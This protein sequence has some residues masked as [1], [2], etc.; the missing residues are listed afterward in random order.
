MLI[1]LFVWQVISMVDGNITLPT[2]VTL[3]LYKIAKKSVVIMK[4]SGQDL[5]QSN[6]FILQTK[7]AYLR[8]KSK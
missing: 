2:C 7:N 3:N 8:K 5:I 4:F 6:F 1:L